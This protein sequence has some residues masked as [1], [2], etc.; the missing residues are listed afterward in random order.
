MI[1]VV[2]SAIGVSVAIVIVLLIR[3]DRLRVANG[4]TWIFAAFVMA[5][6]GFTPGVFDYLAS[7]VGIS[8][9]PALA[10]SVAFGMVVIKLLLDDIHRTQLQIK[11]A[12]LIQRV[13]L[14]E[15]ELKTVNDEKT[16]TK[17]GDN[18]K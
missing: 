15:Y 14:L 7:M 1:V 3:G 13:A 12:R 8:Y 5:G 9:P 6:L 4:L 16:G 11:Q 2:T 18:G 17:N 10:F